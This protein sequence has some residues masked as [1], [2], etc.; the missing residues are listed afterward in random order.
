MKIL[1]VTQCF[2]PDIYTVNDLVGTLVQRGHKVTVLTGLPDYTTS[3][4]PPEYKRGRNRRQDYRGAKILRCPTIARRHG[5]FF[6]CLNYLSFVVS[7]WLYAAFKQ[8]EEFDVIYVWEV[9]PVTMAVPAIRLKKRYQKPLFLYCMDIWPECIKAMGFQEQSIL[10][11]MVHRWSAHIYR[12][13]DH[14]AVSSKPFFDYL[15][16]V[17]GCNRSYM[18]YL[19][20]YGSSELLNQALEKS[21][22]GHTD[23]LY[24]GNIGKVSDV[25][26][27][28]KACARLNTLSIG[29]KISVH[30]VGT[31]SEIDSV[32]R[33]AAEWKLGD[34][35]TFYGSVP[36]AE[37]L[38]Y[39]RNADAC[40]LTLNGNNLIG[41]TL[42]GKLQT[43]MAAG[44]PIIAAI[45][46]AGKEVIE[47]SGCGLC[48]SAGDDEGL[49][50][51]MMEFAENSAQY[52][53]CGENSRIYFEREFRKESHFE[54]LEM[55]LA[56]LCRP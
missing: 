34:M 25:S 8:W 21:P 29:Q 46:G 44:K 7:G 47:D 26:V 37:T 28:L 40:L 38:D 24:I 4:I 35:V 45:N 32:K 36:V 56:R 50:R 52:V 31:G 14:I 13:C 39:Y 16:G 41:S 30:I 6:R 51:I 3:R 18:S 5:A 33:K 22:N 9:S 19:P 53:K 42:P 15:E 2:W 48:V 20:Q 54:R 1:V 55:A 23:F 11:K 49:A 12:K 43:Y 17:N 27:I 10:F